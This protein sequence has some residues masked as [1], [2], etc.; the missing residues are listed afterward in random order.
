MM[1]AYYL[2]VSF[3]LHIIS[4]QRYQLE[5][6]KFHELLDLFL[7]TNRSSASGAASSVERRSEVTKS[8]PSPRKQSRKTI[9][10]LWDNTFG[11]QQTTS[12]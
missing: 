10:K 6:F 5:N 3:S 9:K 8:S 2:E 12:F 7:D 11:E 4:F 1:P